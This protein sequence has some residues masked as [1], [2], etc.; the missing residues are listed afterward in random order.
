L[1]HPDWN[2]SYRSPNSPPWDIGK[3]QPVFVNL[4]KNHEMVPPGTVLDV[5][6][7]T[8]ENAIF[9]AQNK[10]TVSGRDLA[11]T[12]IDQ[13]RSKAKER[14]V[15][16]DFQEG[17][18]LALD[19]K[20]GSF[21]YVTDSGLFH[22]FSDSQ[23]LLFRDEIARVLKPKGV[24]FMMCFSDKE[25]TNWGGPRRV[26]KEEIIKTFSPRFKINYIRD[27]LFATKIHDKGGRAYLTSATRL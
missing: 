24:Y 7:G 23:R 2:Q 20:A 5:G 21:D 19:F 4:V 18:A 10:F 1:S 22:T 17:N 11:E 8:G 25:P 27:A 6:C 15:K 3:P 16:V 13:A 12:A 14:N 9:F 26:S